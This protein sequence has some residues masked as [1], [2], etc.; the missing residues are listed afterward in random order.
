M[1]NK[2][3]EVLKKSTSVGITFHVSP[4]GDSLGSALA[5]MLVLKKLGKEAYIVSSDKIPETYSFLPYLNSIM[6]E[7]RISENSLDSI[8]VLDCGNY[9]RISAKIDFDKK[10]YTLVNI[11]HHISNDFYGDINFID[12]K[13]SSVGELIFEIMKLLQVELDV[14]I[15]TC[16]YTSILSDTGGFKHSN[17]T[18]RTHSIVSE[19]LISGVKFSDIHRLIFENKKFNHIKLMGKVIDS[20]YLAF[21]NQVCVMKFTKK[22]LENLNIELTDTSYLVDLGMNI[23]SVEAAVLIK[24]CDECVKVSLR[25]KSFLDVRKIAESFGGGGHI[26]A[27]GATLKIGV[28]EA[29]DVILKVIEK[30]LI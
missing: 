28:K 7:F 26:R 14:D 24:E 13:A 20:S 18:S 11:D 5:L 25:S 8:V 10:E 19:L 1:I 29:E 27:A 17:T 6:N 4:D 22:M 30:E 3:V 21:S 2:V 15:A 12:T 16:I 23:D 9:E